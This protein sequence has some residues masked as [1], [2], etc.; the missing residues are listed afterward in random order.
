L[1][2]RWPKDKGARNRYFSGHSDFFASET[3]P[4][5]FSVRREG[6]R[7]KGSS[8]LNHPEQ[9]KQCTNTTAK[10]L[11]E[12]PKKRYCNRSIHLYTEPHD[13]ERSKKGARVTS[14]AIACLCVPVR[15]DQASAPAT[16]HPY[17]GVEMSAR[18]NPS[19]SVFF[20]SGTDRR[21]VRRAQE[22]GPATSVSSTAQ[23]LPS[24]SPETAKAREKLKKLH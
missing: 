4:V 1:V 14:P 7:L 19:G 11:P 9:W 3:V 22:C 5:T 21:L 10:K 18:K 15:S 23:A 20:S 17:A 2:T 8:F 16:P 12:W 6:E 13:R 24:I